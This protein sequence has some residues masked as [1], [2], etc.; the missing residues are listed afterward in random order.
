ML[1]R[2]KN[3]HRTS[4]YYKQLA[5]CYRV[6]RRSWKSQLFENLRNLSF[7]SLSPAQLAEESHQL[8][9]TYENKV[10]PLIFR[11]ANTLF[12]IFSQTHFM[13][14]SLTMLS[15]L[16][17][18]W[19]ILRR[20]VNLLRLLNTHCAQDSSDLTIRKK[21]K[22]KRG[23]Q[24]RQS[25]KHLP[26]NT[27]TLSTRENKTNTESILWNRLTFTCNE[28][29]KFIHHVQDCDIDDIFSVLEA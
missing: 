25:S 1:Y 7:H 4:L 27:K 5:K 18:I 19:V 6:L 13:A 14:W 11:A 15:I 9:N 8:L 21:M 10:L 22:H 24:L 29:Q 3:Q 12:S 20:L 23:K 16:A 26:R 2:N 17:R 28:E